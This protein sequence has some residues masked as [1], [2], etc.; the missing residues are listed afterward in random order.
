MWRDTDAVGVPICKYW[1]VALVSRAH[2]AG[3]V[4]W[5]YGDETEVGHAFLGRGQCVEIRLCLCHVNAE[6][7]TKKRNPFGMRG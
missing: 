7:V 2:A 4:G 3:G 6:V 1:P 5:R